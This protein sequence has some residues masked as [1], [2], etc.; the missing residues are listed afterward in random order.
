MFWREE[1]SLKDIVCTKS[2][3]AAYT[4]IIYINVPPETIKKRCNINI[5]KRRDVSLVTYLLKWQ[6][7]KLDALLLLCREHNILL[8]IVNIY[9]I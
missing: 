2:N 5:A 9:Q 1:D 8:S 3:L 4:H 6:Q 7:A